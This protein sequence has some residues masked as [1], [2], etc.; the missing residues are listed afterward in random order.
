MTMVSDRAHPVASRKS[1]FTTDYCSS[2]PEDGRTTAILR[3]FYGPFL[4][5][6]TPYFLLGV[7]IFTAIL[8]V[9][10]QRAHFDKL[11]PNLQNAI[12]TMA[13]T[14]MCI[15]FANDGLAGGLKDIPITSQ[16]LFVA[17]FSQKGVVW[18]SNARRE[19]KRSATEHHASSV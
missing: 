18:L 16:C 9:A 17:V 8:A 10:S 2:R 13:V 15:N 11:G 4:F 1:R 7:A 12:L 5:P 6:T 19:R 3:R 14:H